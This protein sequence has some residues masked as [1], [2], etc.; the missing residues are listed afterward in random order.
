MV[1]RWP[2]RT[3]A[4]LWE[5]ISDIYGAILAHPFITGLTDGT[6]PE[7]SF[8]FYVIQDALYLTGVRA[9]PGG[10]RRV[11]HPQRPRCACS[12]V[13]RRRRSPRNSSCTMHS[14][15]GTG[16][17]Q[18]GRG[19]RRARADEPGLY[20]LPC[21]PLSAV[22]AT[23]KVSVSCLPC[24]WIYAAGRQGTCSALA[25][26]ILAIGDGSRPM[27]RRST[28]SGRRRGDRRA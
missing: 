2:S 28:R 18:G 7:Q 4:R 19:A 17:I 9:G 3:A 20:Q 21:S 24:Y 22:A 26:P 12:P 15:R 13:T 14:P 5:S 6:L 16:N 1:A 23:R 11:A 8:A 25:H 27:A 10:G